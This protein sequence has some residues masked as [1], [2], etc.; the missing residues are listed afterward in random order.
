MEV[1]SGVRGSEM[2]VA[3]RFLLTSFLHRSK[4]ISLNERAFIAA[5]VIYPSISHI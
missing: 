3:E 2:E 4:N 5:I 1:G